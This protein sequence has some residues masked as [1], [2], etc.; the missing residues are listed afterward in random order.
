[1]T[2]STQVHLA[3][4]WQDWASCSGR[5]GETSKMCHQEGEGEPLSFQDLQI[6]NPQHA[7]GSTVASS[8]TSTNVTCG[9]WEMHTCIT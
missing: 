7:L 4:A 5:K 3:R 9:V 8:R 2:L 1:M 6:S